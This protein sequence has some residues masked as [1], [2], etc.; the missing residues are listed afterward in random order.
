MNTE[1]T[2]GL[3]ADGQFHTTHWSVVLAAREGESTQAT[4]AMERLCRIYWYPLY[5]FIRRRGFAVEDAQDM[6]QEF[7]SRML[8]RDF[9][10][11]V[12]R[13]KGR[14][15]TFLLTALK[16]FLASEWRRGQTAK[17]GG[18]QLI[19]SWDE[20]Q[21][22]QRYGS[23]P[24]EEMTPEHFFEQRWAMAVMEQAMSVLAAELAAT[25]KAAQ[26]E[27]F[28]PFLSAEGTKTDY[29]SAAGQLGMTPGAVSVAVHRLRRRFS[30]AVRSVVGHTVAGPD[31]VEEE[32]QFLARVLQ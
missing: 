8:Q 25:G 30:E 24:A 9:L 5:G 32:V 16:N 13:E 29:E 15:R 10:K 20:L 18:G 23:E 3:V 12:A 26:F 28:K 22:E 17:R 2:N 31:Q 14:F 11:N 1:K 6:T 4:S 19:V 27:C 7:F 21:A